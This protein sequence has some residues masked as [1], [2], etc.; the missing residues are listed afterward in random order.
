[1]KIM[2]RSLCRRDKSR[3]TCRMVFT[4][5]AIFRGAVAFPVNLGMCFPDVKVSV[6]RS[7]T[8][9]CSPAFTWSQRWWLSASW[10]LQ[11]K[12]YP[13]PRTDAAPTPGESAHTG[14]HSQVPRPRAKNKCLGHMPFLWTSPNCTHTSLHSSVCTNN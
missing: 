6:M 10:I 14:G 2:T 8:M 11:T 12:R 9:L 3:T 4:A 7:R 1:M 5:D 13:A